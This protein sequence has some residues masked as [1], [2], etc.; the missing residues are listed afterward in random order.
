M[1]RETGRKGN[2]VFGRDAKSGARMDLLATAPDQKLQ[3]NNLA[4]ATICGTFF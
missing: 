3:A 4:L 1:S 2:P